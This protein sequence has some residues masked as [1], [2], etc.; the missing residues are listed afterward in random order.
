MYNFDVFDPGHINEV[1]ERD[2]DT[3]ESDQTLPAIL[4]KEAEYLGMLEYSKDQEEK[5]LKDFNRLEMVNENLQDEV[6]ILRGGNRHNR[7]ISNVSM[8]SFIMEE[9]T[10]L[11]VGEEESA[12]GSVTGRSSLVSTLDRRDR[13][14]ES[15]TVLPENGQQD[16]GLM[17]KLQ[18]AL[19][20]VHMEKEALERTLDEIDTSVVGAERQSAEILKLQKLEV[21]NGKL[22]K[23]MVRLRQAVASRLRDAGENEAAREMSDQFEA[24][25]EE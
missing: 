6:N 22:L 20:D 2:P 9:D 16:V 15:L 19:K 25:Q 13:Q 23:D 21:K 7:T 8:T 11:S 14:L 5:L 17:M 3:N 18:G 24:M 4:K 12:Y 10:N 1:D